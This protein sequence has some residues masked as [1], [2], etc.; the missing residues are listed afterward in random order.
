MHGIVPFRSRAAHLRLLIWSIRRVASSVIYSLSAERRVLLPAIAASDPEPAAAFVTVFDDEI[1]Q[2]R[3]GDQ[4]F[5]VDR[6]VREFSFFQFLVDQILALVQRPGNLHRHQHIRQLT[7]QRRQCLSFFPR[8]SFLILTYMYS[9][10]VSRRQQHNITK[11]GMSRENNGKDQI[12]KRQLSA[13]NFRGG[14]LT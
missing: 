14:C 10:A 4:V 12:Y 1:D 11:P 3:F 7:Q 8:S 9:A 6:I 13:C 2:I 5:P